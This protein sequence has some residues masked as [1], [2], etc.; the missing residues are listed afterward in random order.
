MGTIRPYLFHMGWYIT[1]LVLIARASVC[2]F[3]A[4]IKAGKNIAEKPS[5][6]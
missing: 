3:G 2:C 4:G 6:R 1:S 5:R